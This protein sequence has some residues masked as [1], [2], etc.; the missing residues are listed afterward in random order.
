MTE[1]RVPEGLWDVATVPEGVVITW[2][3]DDGAAVDAGAVVAE[4]M[5]EK[6]Q[7]QIEAPASGRLQIQAPVDS[8]VVPGSVIGML[9][10]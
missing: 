1:I 5:V 3:F 10:A 6:T 7:Y 4:I 8:A 2:F 9:E